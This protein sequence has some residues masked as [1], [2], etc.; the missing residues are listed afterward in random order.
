MFYKKRAG[1]LKFSY[2]SMRFTYGKGNIVSS[3]RGWR[4]KVV[5]FFIFFWKKAPY[6]P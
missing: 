2:P 4:E 1:V 6:H 3:L 5:I